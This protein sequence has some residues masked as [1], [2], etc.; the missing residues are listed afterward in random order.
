MPGKQAAL[1]ATNTG[2]HTL[3]FQG[4]SLAKSGSQESHQLAANSKLCQGSS[5]A[6]LLEPGAEP[7]PAGLKGGGLEMAANFNESMN[8]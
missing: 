3:P 7:V 2:L 8:E 4:S 5:S 6:S 1:S